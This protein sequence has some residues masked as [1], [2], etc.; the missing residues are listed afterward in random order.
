MP[1]FFPTPPASESLLLHCAYSTQADQQV[2]LELTM[3]S[4]EIDNP[5]MREARI[6]LAALIIS[7][8]YS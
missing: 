3:D 4:L 7:S 1:H 6:H 2:C 5:C 8:R